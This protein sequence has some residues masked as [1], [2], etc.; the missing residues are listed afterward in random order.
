MAPRARP[1]ATQH[2]V[3][4]T[5]TAPDTHHRGGPPTL[6]DTRQRRPVR[7]RPPAAARGSSDPRRRPAPSQPSQPQ[8]RDQP[9]RRH[10][11][12]G[13][14]SASPV[15]AAATASRRTASRSTATA[16]RQAYGQPAGTPA[17]EL[18]GVG[19]PRRR[20]SAAC[21]SASRRSSSRRRSTRSTPAGDLAGA[22][23][24]SRQGQAVR[25]L[26]GAWRGI[27]VVGALPRRDRRRCSAGERLSP[28]AWHDRQPRTA[29][30]GAA[31]G[32]PGRPPLR[33]RGRSR[34]A[35]VGYVAAVDPNESGHYP[36][37]PFLAVTGLLL[38]G[39]RVAARDARAGARRPRRGVRRATLL[40]VARR[41]VPLV[42]A[43]GRAGCAGPWTGRGAALPHPP[44]VHLGAAR[45][46][47]RRSAC[48]A[49]CRRVPSL[50]P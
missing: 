31:P 14:E 9:G 2:H 23:E 42:V 27:V 50:A 32:R 41:A 1:D 19:D 29:P 13:G 18:P 34:A 17:A 37:C 36:T 7:P 24:S 4:A 15:R 40:A 26:V 10:P 49:T 12:A 47:G 48:C 45:R 28:A 38:P 20:C 44:C 43:L 5:S 33:R 11:L 46:R 30:G 8:R 3:S 39:L 16:V 21:R 35:A 6:S 25:H 22:Q